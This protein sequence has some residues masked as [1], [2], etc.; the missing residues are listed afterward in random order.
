MRFDW[1]LDRFPALRMGSSSL[2]KNT[3]WMVAGDGVRVLVQAVYFVLIARTLDSVGYGA[4]A[5][6]AALVSV[7]GPFAAWGWGPLLI[8][9]VSRDRSAFPRYWGQSI[10]VTVVSGFA[11]TVLACAVSQLVFGNALPLAL[12]AAL[13][14]ADL[15]AYRLLVICG[16]AFQAHES[17]RR[18]AIMQLM[19]SVA[20]LA[21]AI[22]L[23][24][25]SVTP[26][27]LLWALFY[28]AS[29]V[30]AASV[31]VVLVLRE[32]GKPQ[33][34]TSVAKADVREGFHFAVLIS[35]QTIYNDIDK[36]ML[37][38]L[39]GFGAAGVYAAAYRIIDVAFVPVRS[40]LAAALPRF[41][42]H[43]E[44]GMAGTIPFA[45]RLLVPSTAYAA[46]AFLALFLGAP[47]ASVLLG[48][49]YAD[50]TRALQFLAIIPLLRTW[51]ILA[52]DSLGGAGYQPWRSR[53]QLS[54]ALV[55]I[56][57]NFALIPA[58][59]WRGAAIASIAS[60][61]LLVLL[62]WTFARV[63]QLRELR[64]GPLSR[65]PA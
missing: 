27:P 63:A 65:S 56:A 29:T 53:I 16:Q 59:S 38:K 57:L 19:L 3:G 12:T 21:A 58:L 9:N 34:G 43:G 42:K 54:V 17:L 32:L 23:G 33:F 15:V 8:K 50:T 18:T 48:A 44:Q 35:S 55:N 60:D 14:I 46:F 2:A 47:V 41:F 36:T 22:I 45:R 25:V 64:T 30:L 52:S 1:L 5:S 24:A 39:G 4:F 51:S 37:G 11:L 13:S 26:T 10:Q 49:D 20:R 7:L 61:G 31:A 62:T 40:M 28:L 6:V